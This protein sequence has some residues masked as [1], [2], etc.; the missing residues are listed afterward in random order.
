M[1]GLTAPKIKIPRKRIKFNIR[2]GEIGA[3]EIE[4]L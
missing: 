1:K 4:C 2:G 3:R